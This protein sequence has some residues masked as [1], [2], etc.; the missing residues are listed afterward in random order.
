MRKPFKRQVNR[1]DMA[2][3]GATSVSLVMEAQSQLVSCSCRCRMV[4][5]MGELIRP[6][7]GG[8]ESVEL[9]E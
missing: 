7:V 9:A 5:Q 3:P 8:D 2:G 4:C 6:C 1:L